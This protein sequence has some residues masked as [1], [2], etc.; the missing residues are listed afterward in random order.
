MSLEPS[1]HFHDSVTAEIA[2]PCSFRVGVVV[3][4]APPAKSRELL[5]NAASCVRG[6]LL[7][8]PFC[9]ARVTLHAVEAAHPEIDDDDFAAVLIRGLMALARASTPTLLEPVVDLELHCSAPHLGD[10]VADLTRRR[11]AQVVQVTTTGAKGCA[12][13]SAPLAE[14]MGYATIVRSLSQGTAHFSTR[15]KSFE[16]VPP[17]EQD[18]LLGQWIIIQKKFPFFF[19]HR[20]YLFS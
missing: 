19:N 1:P 5:Q 17:R 10:V 7:G 11:R 8:F 6:S 16:R 13:A 20:N 9:Q 12:M 4:A 15:L 14:M 3:M 18:R 2:S